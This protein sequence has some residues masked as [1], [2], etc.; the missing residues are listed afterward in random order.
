MH[1]V[2]EVGI[3]SPRTDTAKKHRR[4]A[5]GIGVGE[6]SNIIKT[7]HKTLRTSGLIFDI[8]SLRKTAFFTPAFK[9]TFPQKFWEEFTFHPNEVWEIR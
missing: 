1:N 2:T 4:L 9:Q 6:Q 3:S 7:K 8:P 5:G